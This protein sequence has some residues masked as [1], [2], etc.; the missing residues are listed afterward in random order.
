[1]SPS[2]KEFV[3]KAGQDGM[4][5]V[6][7]GQVALVKASSAEVKAFA[8]RMM[9]DHGT[10]NEELKQL[11]TIKG[12]ALATGVREPHQ[13]AARHLEG[14]SGAAFDKAYMQHMVEDHQEAVRDFQNAASTATDADLKRW[15][16]QKLPALQ[17]HLRQ[18]E[19]LASRMR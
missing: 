7:I 2:D 15:A 9:N 14:L 13:Q 5:E 16:T 10:A 6:R 18:A 12:L 3:M 4:A 17:E 11:A 8:Q 1:M 19:A